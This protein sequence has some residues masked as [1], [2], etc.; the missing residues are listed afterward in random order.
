ML[1]SNAESALHSG[2]YMELLKAILQ[3]R[4]VV[5]LLSISYT[6]ILVSYPFGKN[7]AI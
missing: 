1:V 2:A 4:H 3:A 5:G 7:L 6:L